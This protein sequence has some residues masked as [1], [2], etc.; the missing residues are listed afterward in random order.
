M[1]SVSPLKCCFLAARMRS[2]S[3]AIYT[4][5]HKSEKDFVSVMEILE[6]TENWVNAEHQFT[7]HSAAKPSCGT[8]D[9]MRN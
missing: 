6:S 7:N 8:M 3:S 1:L 9:T 2:E 4:A 5:G